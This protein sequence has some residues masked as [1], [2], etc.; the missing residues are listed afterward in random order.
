MKGVTSA[1]CAILIVYSHR[2][3]INLI[4]FSQWVI[5]EAHDEF[6]K[7]YD[8]L[9]QCKDA[10]MPDGTMGISGNPQVR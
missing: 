3:G 10:P 2:A 6:Q 7:G 9:K 5:L 4:I 1:V 8:L